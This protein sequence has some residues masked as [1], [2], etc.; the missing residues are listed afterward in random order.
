MN[1]VLIRCWFAN[2]VPQLKMLS[3]LT[4]TIMSTWE[5]TRLYWLAMII[6]FVVGTLQHFFTY[7]LNTFEY[8]LFL[9]TPARIVSIFPQFSFTVICTILFILCCLPGVGF[10]CLHFFY[11]SLIFFR[12][13]YS[14]LANRFTAFFSSDMNIMVW[15]YIMAK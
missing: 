2:Y 3:S 5:C 14:S 8:L 12:F 4:K 9:A 7:W 15:P 10:G 6:N 11:Q 1:Y 13:S